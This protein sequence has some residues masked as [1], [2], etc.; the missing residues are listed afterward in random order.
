MKLITFPI[1][2]NGK[3][4]EMFIAEKAISNL[5]MDIETSYIGMD[6]ASL[7]NLKPINPLGQVPILEID[8]NTH[9]SESTAICSYLES[10]YPEKKL[11]G[12][13]PLE[14]A[15][16]EMWQRR[17]EL[18]FFI[19]VVEYGHHTHE[20]FKN[21]FNQISEFGPYYKIK[22][23]KTIDLLEEQLRTH[24]YIAGDAFSV[25]DITAYCGLQ[26][27]LIYQIENLNKP[28]IIEWRTRIDTRPTSQFAR[29]SF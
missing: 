20:F 13:T 14:K 19:P 17:V 23:L 3:R 11:L 12:N 8:E 9:L 10:S 28:A 6:P 4:I 5:G 15:T 16:I 7:Q 26:L 25:A 22:I 21:S 1:A 24:S 18:G 27:A 29:Y 2:P